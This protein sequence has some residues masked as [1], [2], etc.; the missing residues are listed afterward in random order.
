MNILHLTLQKLE[1]Y[2]RKNTEKKLT[3]MENMLRDDSQEHILLKAYYLHYSNTFSKYNNLKPFQF[4]T[5]TATLLI[6]SLAERH[7]I[8][9]LVLGI[10]I[11]ILTLIDIS[12]LTAGLICR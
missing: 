9:V 4:D 8:K 1:L 6:K 7:T 10:K 5:D 11:A 3:W 12:G 2:Y